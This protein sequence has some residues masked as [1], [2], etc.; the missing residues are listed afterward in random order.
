[1]VLVSDQYHLWLRYH[2]AVEIAAIDLFAMYAIWNGKEREGGCKPNRSRLSPTA[3]GAP[4]VRATVCAA[5]Y[6]VRQAG[7]KAA[8]KSLQDGGRVTSLSA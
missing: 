4:S 3:F 2:P 1:M 7:L 8:R 5:Q 6:I